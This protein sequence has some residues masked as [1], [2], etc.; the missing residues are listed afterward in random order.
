MDDSETKEMRT[1]TM[2]DVFRYLTDQECKYGP[3]TDENYKRSL[4][5][6]ATNFSVIDGTHVY[7]Y[8]IYA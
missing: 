7:T 5:R 6:K 4:R 2:N 3:N 8:E 1:C